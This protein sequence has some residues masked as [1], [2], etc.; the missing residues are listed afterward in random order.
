[1]IEKR[2]LSSYFTYCIDNFWI[3]S[4]PVGSSQENEDKVSHNEQKKEQFINYLIS[5]KQHQ[6]NNIIAKSSSS[7]VE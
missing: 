6:H 3:V 1:V 2:L 7:D 5:I 4:K